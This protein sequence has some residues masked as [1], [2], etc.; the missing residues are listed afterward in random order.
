MGKERRNKKESFS[1]KNEWVLKVGGARVHKKREREKIFRLTSGKRAKGRRSAAEERSNTSRTCESEST[2]LNGKGIKE[3]LL[4]PHLRRKRG[5][6]IQHKNRRKE[7]RKKWSPFPPGEE[8]KGRLNLISPG[9]EKG[10]KKE[11]L[12]MGVTLKKG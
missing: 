6:V 10:R 11:S 9:N 5:R 12:G 2:A 7:G 4:P 1:R 8:E 3:S